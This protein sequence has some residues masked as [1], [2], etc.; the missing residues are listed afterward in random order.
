MKLEINNE[1]RAGKFT[2]MQKLNN[3]LEQS[4]NQKF[5]NM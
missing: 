4:I 2:Y 1:G 3:T 5:K